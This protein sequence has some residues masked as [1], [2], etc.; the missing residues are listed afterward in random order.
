MNDE[1][2]ESPELHAPEPT[3]PWDTPEPPKQ[4]VSL[5]ELA[6]PRSTDFG[7]GRCGKA[8][9]SAQALR[10]HRIRVHTA[11]GK[12]GAMRGSKRANRNRSEVLAARRE[13]QQRLRDRYYAEGRNSKGQLMPPGWKPNP[14]KHFRYPS[15]STEYKRAKYQE[16]KQRNRAAGLNAR[17]KPLKTKASEAMKASWAR[18]KAAAAAENSNSIQEPPGATDYSGEAARAILLAAK[19]IRGVAASLKL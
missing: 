2:P 15:D 14:R 16:Y 10:M 13:Y 9:D 1:S 8:F 5:D 11:A 19:V 7:C 3:M 6:N 17:G 12:A 4:T 18:R